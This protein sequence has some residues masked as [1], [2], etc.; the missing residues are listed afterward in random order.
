MTDLLV[1]DI[2]VGYHRGPAVVHD[3]SLTV[4]SGEILAVV[5]RN[6]AGKTTLLRALSGLLPC[7]R[8]SVRLKGREVA[9]LPPERVA[10]SGMAHVPAGR[11]VIPG[12]TTL[13]NLKLGAYQLTGSNALASALDDVLTMLPALANWVGRRAGTLSGGEQQLLAIGRALMPRPSVL[14]LDEP[15]T[16]LSPAYQLDVLEKLTEIAKRGTAILL[17]E[18][19]VR[20][21]LR[22]ADRGMVL[23]EGRLVMTGTAAELLTE[24]RLEAGYLGIGDAR[25]P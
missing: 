24:D 23:D 5:G 17:V 1:S 15:L 19:N 7:R 9:G 2:E 10:R 4:E 21:S 20:R 3:L 14:L 6:G 12:M 8:G 18:Q 16:G 25:R 22:V 13:D 11:R